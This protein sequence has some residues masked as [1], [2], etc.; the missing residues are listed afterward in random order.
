MRLPND[1]LIFGHPVG[2]PIRDEPVYVF[3]LPECRNIVRINSLSLCVCV[4]VC[5]YINQ[6]DFN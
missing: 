1:K 2:Q 5:V 4:C 6:T 3:D